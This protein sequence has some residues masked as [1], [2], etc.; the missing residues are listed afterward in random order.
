MIS[1]NLDEF[2][3]EMNSAFDIELNVPQII[4]VKTRS[5]FNKET[6]REKTAS[7]MVARA[8]VKQNKIVIFAKDCIEKETTN[9]KKEEF[10]VIIKHELVHFLIEQKYGENIPLWIHEGLACNIAEQKKKKVD[11]CFKDMITLSTEKSFYEDKLAFPK[12]YWLVRNAI[13][14][15]GGL[16]QWLKDLKHQ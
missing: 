5:E 10:E 2:V 13:E 15:E 1:A 6:N 12:S 16:I 11:V 14:K 4:T 9:H 7:W 8:D 3:K